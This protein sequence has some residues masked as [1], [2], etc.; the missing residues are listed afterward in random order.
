[1]PSIKKGNTNQ[2]PIK[3]ESVSNQMKVRE[4]IQVKIYI[5][6]FIKSGKYVFLLNVI[7]NRY[8]NLTP[9]IKPND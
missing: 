3:I 5:W 6:F 2:F 4:S 7:S 9:R 1:M 8:N